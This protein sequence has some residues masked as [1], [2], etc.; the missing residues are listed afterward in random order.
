MKEELT[1]ESLAE[2]QEHQLTAVLSKLK[3]DAVGIQIRFQK[4][5]KELKGILMHC[6]YTH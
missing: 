2:M 5:C 6:M 4:A 3:I 1:L